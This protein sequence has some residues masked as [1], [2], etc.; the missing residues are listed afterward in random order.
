MPERFCL[1]FPAQSVSGRPLQGDAVYLRDLASP[2]F[3]EEARK[4]PPSKILKLAFLQSMIRQPDSAAETL[5]V[6]RDEI[7]EL[8]DVGAALDL[9]VRESSLSSS[10]SSYEEL[11]AAFRENSSVFYP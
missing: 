6:F 3:Q 7:G 4:L 1:S 9:L 2:E 11:M 10:F 5:L 8:L